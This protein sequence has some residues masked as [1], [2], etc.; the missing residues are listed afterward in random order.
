[1]ELARTPFEVEITRTPNDG[2]Q[3]NEWCRRMGGPYDSDELR[4][5]LFDQ[6]SEGIR[7]TVENKGICGY[8]SNHPGLRGIEFTVAA[9]T[10]VNKFESCAALQ[11]R[12]ISHT[13]P[14]C[15]NSVSD[16]RSEHYDTVSERVVCGRDTSPGINPDFKRDNL[17]H[18]WQ[19]K[20]AL[21]L[22]GIHFFN[23]NGLMHRFC[24]SIAGEPGRNPLSAAP[25]V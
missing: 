9:D 13:G 1:M 23:D 17:I 21:L 15:R 14:A 5:T 6:R 20:Q 8:L 16:T 24:G 25:D 11:L 7:E 3:K 19:V 4:E 2:L 10:E 12:G 22:R 18:H